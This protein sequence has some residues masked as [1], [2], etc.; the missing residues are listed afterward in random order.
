M[1]WMLYVVPPAHGVAAS[2]VDSVAAL[3]LRLRMAHTLLAPSVVGAVAEMP[4]S[5]RRIS[6]V[7]GVVRVPVRAE[8]TCIL[9]EVTAA[10]PATVAYLSMVT[11]PPDR[12]LS[13]MV[14]LAALFVEANEP[15]K[16]SELACV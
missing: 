11:V 2:A 4:A 10:V 12:P 7:V 8:A 5:Q 16:P 9:Y 13:V 6:K 15:A 14:K 3:A 1:T